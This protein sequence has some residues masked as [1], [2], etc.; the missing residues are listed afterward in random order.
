VRSPAVL[1]ALVITTASAVSFA[2]PPVAKV[3]IVVA[4]DPDAIA[5]GA[6]SR[7]ATAISLRSDVRGVADADTRAVLRGETRPDP[8]LAPLVTLRRALTGGD[9]DS[10]QLESIGQRLGCSLTVEIAARP[11]G[12]TL[13]NFDVVHRTFDASH[14][15]A[16]VDATAVD[17][18]ILAAARASIAADAPAV[19]TSDSPPSTPPAAAS[20]NVDAT[21]NANSATNAAPAAAAPSGTAA[22]STPAAA[23]VAPSTS[24]ANTVTVTPFASTPAVAPGTTTIAAPSPA[25]VA[26]LAGA[27]PAVAAS[28]PA[29]R[30]HAPTRSDPRVS[31][32]TG[33]IPADT[34]GP[35]IAGWIVAG[36]AAVALI[37][38]FIIVQ[39]A[40][41]P[42][43]PPISVMHTGASP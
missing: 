30:D 14:T 20:V 16:T 10:V 17:R 13:R 37:A 3:C 27:T 5:R 15:V 1:A 29:A 43:T 8:S 39:A 25:P 9:T 4:G 12:L 6:A 41:G 33:E 19:A 23:T 32:N 38:V 22:S 36:S 31:L 26:A 28:T 11:A 40:S 18:W 35:G 2:D 34:G 42:S 21:A 24:P 7:I